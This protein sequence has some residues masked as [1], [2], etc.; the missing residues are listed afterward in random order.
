MTTLFK[1]L[2]YC[3]LWLLHG[4]GWCL[5]WLTFLLSASYRRQFVANV[6]Q[7]QLRWRQWRGAVG[8][9]G[10]LVAELPRLWLGAPVSVTWQGEQYI[11][12]AMQRGKGLIFLTPHL[13]SFEITAQDYAKRFGQSYQPITV[14]FRPSRQAWLSALVS[15]A[16]DRPGMHGAPTTLAGVKQMIKALRRGESVGLLPDQVPPIGMGVLA[17]FFGRNAYTMTLS[18]RLAQQ[19][20]AT[21]LMVWGERLS[22]G[23]GFFVHVQPMPGD[24]PSDVGAAVT[25]INRAMESLVLQCPDQYLWGYARYKT[26]RQIL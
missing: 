13:G 9:S 4:L 3:P 6:G 16:R 5:G 20:G 8:E 10:K 23:R 26:P 15:G 1:L 24:L 18:V 7:A 12:E 17:P 22:W 14:L 19:T 21:V 25:S 11:I 2:S